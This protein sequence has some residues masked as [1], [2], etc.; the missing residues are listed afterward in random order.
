M[1]DVGGKGGVWKEEGN[2]Y[3]TVWRQGVAEAFVEKK[4]KGWKRAL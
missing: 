3:A 4:I 2:L 1:G